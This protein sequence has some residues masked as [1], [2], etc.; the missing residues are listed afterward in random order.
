MYHN[1][2]KQ[3]VRVCDITIVF[4][5][6]VGW[7]DMSPLCTSSTNWTIVPHTDDRWIWSIWWNEN[8]QGRQ[9]Y[10]E[11]TCPNATLSTTNP[12]WSDVGSSPD[13]RCGKP[14]TN[15][16]NDARPA[17]CLS[18]WSLVL[19]KLPVVQLIKNFS[20]FYGARRFITVFTRALHGRLHILLVNVSR[21]T[22]EL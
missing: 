17:N 15:C 21:F 13:H 5:N 2:C 7:G 9:K 12:T 20:S 14:A 19:D 8:W 11:K 1:K 10:W 22:L 3:N 6:F 16:L 4:F 18:P